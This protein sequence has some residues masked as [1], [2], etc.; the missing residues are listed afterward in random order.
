MTARRGRGL[1]RRKSRCL[2]C[3]HAAAAAAMN[4]VIRLAATPPLHHLSP[5]TGSRK[6]GLGKRQ[7][8]AADHQALH[9]GKMAEGRWSSFPPQ[10][11][12]LSATAFTVMDELLI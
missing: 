11:T 6:H 5:A 1:R 2:R 12:G 8:P 4:P 7:D 10:H 3:G 9:T